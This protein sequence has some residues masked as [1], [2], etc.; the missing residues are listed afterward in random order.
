MW[1]DLTNA[2]FVWYQT[3]SHVKTTKLF[4]EHHYL[5]QILGEDFEV[6]SLCLI[7]FCYHHFAVQ[8]QVSYTFSSYPP[9]LFHNC[10]NNPNNYTISTRLLLKQ[11]GLFKKKCCLGN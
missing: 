3:E 2:Y 5:L 4:L 6:I 11:I 9:F 7:S 10:F 1:D 8:Q